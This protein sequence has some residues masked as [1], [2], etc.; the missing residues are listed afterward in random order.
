MKQKFIV[1]IWRDIELTKKSVAR[2]KGR[3]ICAVVI[4]KESQ[5]T[6]SAELEADSLPV[7]ANPGEKTI[8]SR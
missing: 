1:A 3:M 2:S 8:W 5:T 4:W 7:L 6:R